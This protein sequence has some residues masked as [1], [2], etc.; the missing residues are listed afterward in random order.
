MAFLTLDDKSE[1]IG[2]YH[3]Q[4]LLFGQ[5]PNANLDYTWKYHPYLKNK[6]IKYANLYV[7]GKDYDEVCP[8]HLKDRWTEL[9]TKA[10]S[11]IRSFFESKVSLKD[12]CFYDLVPRKFL[13]DYCDIKCQ[14]IDYIIKNYAQPIDY[15]F[16]ADLESLLTELRNQKITFDEIAIKNNLQDQRIREFWQNYKSKDNYINYNQFHSKTGRLTTEE[17]SFPILNLSKSLRTYI[18]PDNDFFLDVD[19]NAAEVRVF[20]ALNGFKQP[21]IDIHEWNMDKFGYSDRNT[22]KNDFIS[23]LYGKKNARE[24]HFKKYYNTDLIKKKYWNGSLVKNYYGREILAD[25]FHSVNYI[26]QSTTA[27]MVLRQV[28]KVNELLKNCQSKIKMIIHDNIVIDLK[29][30]EKELV[31]K[32]VDSY[33]DTEFGKFKS[34]IKIGKSL[35]DMR[36]IL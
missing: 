19:Y 16:K 10:K 3:N 2:F 23:W 18:K 21:T 36:K 12:N 34:S 22:A 8:E 28:L 14:I 27:D 25:E 24:K 26:V 4:E 31:K 11:Y 9:N 30:E 35:G 15:N 32:I 7:N 6:N 13:I 17:N 33:N 1:C 29:K 20:L 5:E